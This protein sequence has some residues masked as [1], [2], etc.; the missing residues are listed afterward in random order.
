MACPAREGMALRISID[1]HHRAACAAGLA[2]LERRAPA[3]V[4]GR[5]ASLSYCIDRGGP[6]G[7][8]RADREG[9]AA[10]R[11]NAGRHRGIAV[12]RVS[13]LSI[14]RTHERGRRRRVRGLWLYD[15]ARRPSRRARG[16]RGRHRRRR[17][18]RRA[19]RWRGRPSGPAGWAP[20]APS[21]PARITRAAAGH[22][23]ALADLGRR[24]RGTLVGPLSSPA[25]AGRRRSGRCTDGRGPVAGRRLPRLAASSRR[26]ARRGAR[27]AS[28][29]PA[30]V[31]RAA[32][33]ARQRQR[34]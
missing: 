25:R 8:S 20:Q 12:G 29:F 3:F 34:S 32:A 9:W 27:R 2:D 13:Q 31:E 4:G 10:G 18:D 28:R 30:S 22:A 23:A 5:A 14:V 6:I 16:C 33:R 1:E 15:P 26:A 17:G 21:P 11:R 19:G 24:A 7:V